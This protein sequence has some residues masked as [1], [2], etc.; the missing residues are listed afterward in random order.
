MKKLFRLE[1][2][3]AVMLVMSAIAVPITIAAADTANVNGEWNLTVETPNGTGTPSVIFKQ[4][5]EN[6]T[7]TYKGRFGE[8]SVKGII[9]GNDI[10]F[11]TTISPQGQDILVEYSGTVDGDTMKGKAKFG[12]LGEGNFSGKRKA[13]ETPAP[14]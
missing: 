3:L 4:D 13:A 6:L 10:K 7:G 8:S 1:V 12:E 14:K 2:I 5:G 11:S 9:K